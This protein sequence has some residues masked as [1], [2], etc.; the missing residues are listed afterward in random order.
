MNNQ[1]APE[2]TPTTRLAFAASFL[3][4]FVLGLLV[5]PLLSAEDVSQPLAFN[6]RVHAEYDLECVDCHTQ[7]MTAA[8]PGLP[9]NAICQD[10]HDEALGESAAEQELL[11]W[12]ANEQPIPWR[13]LFRQPAHVFFSHRR[14][15][16]VGGLDCSLC[17]G[18]FGQLE[19]PPTSVPTKLTMEQCEDCHT[20]SEVEDDCTSCHR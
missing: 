3:A 2:P 18:D 1:V 9:A 15:A 12:L 13:P 16:N 4:V 20:Q 7:V 11:E 5:W 10:C 17:H 8:V 19:S 14:H 6:H